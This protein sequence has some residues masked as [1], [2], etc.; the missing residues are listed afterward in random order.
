MVGQWTPRVRRADLTLDEPVGYSTLTLVENLGTPDVLLLEGDLEQLRGAFPDDGSLDHGMVVADDTGT[1]RFSGVLSNP[2]RNV[3]GTGTVSFDGDLVRL[4]DRFVWPTPANAWTSQSTAYDVQTGPS[5]TRLLHYI[6]VNAG[7]GARTER[8]VAGLRL[9]TTA[10]RGTSAKTSARFGNLLDLVSKLALDAGLRL[11]VV[12]TYE[13]GVPYLDVTLTA[14]VDLSASARYGTPGFSGPGLLGDGSYS[15]Q[16]PTGN[17]VLCA[18]GGTGAS[19]TLNSAQDTASVTAWGRRIEGFVD[20]R[21]TTDATEIAQAITD[22]LAEGKAQVQVA[23]T[24]TDSPALRLGVD[25]PVGA[26]VTAVIDGQILTERVTS[27]TTVVGSD[28]GD[29]PTV[30]VSATF[31]SA[32]VPIDLTAKQAAGMF[33]RLSALEAAP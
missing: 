1:R 4:R 6:D 19:R 3:D 17:V 16:S 28:A 11:T 20:Q 33:A 8:R 26:L 2:V 9:P 10:A 18:A 32:D 24:I 13:S 12:Q 30:D 21:Q 7:P 23:A 14:L 29:A 5:E 27:I 22:A 31:G 15:V 25:V